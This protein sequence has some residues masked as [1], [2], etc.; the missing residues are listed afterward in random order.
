MSKQQSLRNIRLEFAGGGQAL[1]AAA[2]GEGG[3]DDQGD[4]EN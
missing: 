2:G 1:E 3:P 4:W